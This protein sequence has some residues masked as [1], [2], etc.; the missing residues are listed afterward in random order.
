MR[1]KK[2]EIDT[3]IYA[4]DIISSIV[5]EKG[6][7]GVQIE[8]NQNLTESELSEQYID[9]PVINDEKESAKVS[10]YVKVID[11]DEKFDVKNN[12]SENVDNSY[13]E[14][15]DNIFSENELSNIIFDLKKEFSKLK[16]LSYDDSLCDNEFIVKNYG[17]LNINIID[18][19]NFDYLN[20]WKEFF[21]PIYIDNIIIKPSFKELKG[22]NNIDDKIIITIDPGGA[23]G[24]GSHETTKLC[25]KSIKNCI[26]DLKN[27]STFINFLDIGCGSGILGIVANKLG[28]KDVMSIDI[29]KSVIE[30]V[31]NNLEHNNV[32]TGFKLL[33]G[34]IIED[35]NIQNEL[36]EYDII[37]SN[38]LAPIIILLLNKVHIYN[39]LKPNGYMILSGILKEKLDDV[40]SEIKKNKNLRVEKIEEDGDWVCITV[41]K[42]QL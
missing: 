29:D 33:I 15:N 40:I 22:K 5:F 31:N 21:E 39:F 8:D 27:K 11:K 20:K 10:F 1:L 12:I 24:T 4:E 3:T 26:N 42:C 6:I 30:T 28:I 32:N 23:F 18:L 38:I 17:S 9:I 19:E 13:I 35:I 41:R 37:V 16:T 25:I 7:V 2:I 36:S 14:S 34:N